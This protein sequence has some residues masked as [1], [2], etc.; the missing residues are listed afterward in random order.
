M[1]ENF[2]VDE[3]YDGCDQFE[4]GLTPAFHYQPHSLVGIVPAFL[5]VLALVFGVGSDKIPSG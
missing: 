1:D 3:N 5:M 2:V 4:F